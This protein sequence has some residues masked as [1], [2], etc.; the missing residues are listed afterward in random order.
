MTDAAADGAAD[1]PG[2]AEAG[3][4]LVLA[5]PHAVAS[6]TAAAARPKSRLRMNCPPN[7]WIPDV[8]R[9]ATRDRAN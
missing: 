3:A 6:I 2:A 4:E 8:S 5:E 7:G 9:Y 1:A